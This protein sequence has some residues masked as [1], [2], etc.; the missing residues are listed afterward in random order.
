MN[1]RVFCFRSDEI[2]LRLR[3]VLVERRRG[4]PG[5]WRR[6]CHMHEFR[7]LPR[8]QA[9]EGATRRLLEDRQ[10]G[11]I[12]TLKWLN[13][14]RDRPGMPPPGRSLVSWQNVQGCATEAIQP[15]LFGMGTDTSRSFTALLLPFPTAFSSGPF[16]PTFPSLTIQVDSQ[17]WYPRVPEFVVADVLHGHLAADCKSKDSA[18]IY[19]N[20]CGPSPSQSSPCRMRAEGSC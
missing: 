17:K 6:A 19:E 11:L 18:Y 15:T 16:L 8:R 10:S 9:Q 2:V 12:G 4:G 7:R 5:T 3:G 13:L 14:T 1:R 20:W